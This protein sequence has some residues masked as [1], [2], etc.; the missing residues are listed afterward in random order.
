MGFVSTFTAEVLVNDESVIVPFAA[1]I[2]TSTLAPEVNIGG[3][4]ITNLLPVASAA[5]TAY[6][7]KAPLIH[8]YAHR[9]LG[10]S[11][12]WGGKSVFGADCS[13]FVQQV[14]KMASIRLPRDASQQA[15]CGELVGFL[16]QA[17][18]GDLAF[19]DNEEGQ[20]THVG[21]MLNPQQIIHSS[22]YVHIDS[23][24]NQ[25]IIHHITGLRT[26]TL[27]VIKRLI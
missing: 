23:I 20:I 15:A 24:D 10:V 11:Y 4:H 19:F 27:R 17:Q 25:G 18:L 13:G 9:Y 21:I 7:D 2:P 8:A 5:T 16:Q 1:E 6:A 26:H 3:Y 22:G 12:L 14:F